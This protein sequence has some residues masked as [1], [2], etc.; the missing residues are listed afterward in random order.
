MRKWSV[1]IGSIGF[2][3]IGAGVAWAD[4][5]AN[6][7]VQQTPPIQLGTSGGSV[8][9]RSNAFCCGGT[10]GSAVLYDGALHILSN[11]HILARSGSAT[12]GEDTLQPGLIDTGCN[13]ANSNIVGD[14]VG[15]LVPLGTANVDAAISLARAN[16]VDT[17]GSIIDIGVPCTEI[18]SPVVGLPVRKSGRTTGFTTGTITATNVTVSIR[19]RRG[20]NSGGQFTITFTNQIATGNMSA[21]GDSGSLTLSNDDGSPN[22]VGLLFAGSS[23]TTIHNRIGDVVNAFSAGGHTFTFAGNSCGAAA[24]AEDGAAL[25]FDTPAAA[26]LAHALQIKEQNENMLFQMK[27]V[28]GVGIGANEN[29]PTEAAIVIFFEPAKGRVAPVLDDTD[30]VPVRVILTDPIVAQ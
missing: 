13:G 18:Q 14:F 4:G 17:S 1:C 29:N 24:S 12:A 6:H 28:H 20:C 7:R 5:G 8:N 22:P 27:G 15:N 21:G 19:Y 2:L 26:D 25:G 11:N 16:M 3:A 30:G 9:D 23:T 10:L